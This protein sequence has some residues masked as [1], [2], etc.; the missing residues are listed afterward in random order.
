MKTTFSL[1]SPEQGSFLEAGRRGL[2]C[3]GSGLRLSLKS[4]L[5]GLLFVLTCAPLIVI[6][7]Q[8]LQREPEHRGLNKLD[9]LP[10]T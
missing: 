5:K 2:G 8:L 9:Y 10:L 6:H 3:R 7:T 1:P 4:Q